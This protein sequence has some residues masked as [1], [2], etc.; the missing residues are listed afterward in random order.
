MTD[1]RKPDSIVSSI[2]LILITLLACKGLTGDEDI[3]AHC[4]K[5]VVIFSGKP[6]YQDCKKHYSRV[7]SGNPE[8][9]ACI[10]ACAA[11]AEKKVVGDGER[12]AKA[13]RSLDYMSCTRG[14]DKGT[15]PSVGGEKTISESERIKI[16]DECNRRRCLPGNKPG[17]PEHMAC[18]AD[19]CRKRGMKKDCRE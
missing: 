19:C 12:L 5:E 1:P 16:I 6:L 11:A 18:M 3:D 4:A 10:Q 7:K 13:N 2:L 8:Q 9:F 15:K 17:S 14:C